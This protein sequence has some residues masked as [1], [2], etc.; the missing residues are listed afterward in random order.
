MRVKKKGKV[1][2][3][4][5]ANKMRLRGFLLK[6]NIAPAATLPTVLPTPIPRLRGLV[7]EMFV[8]A[9]LAWSGRTTYGM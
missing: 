8:P 9:A 4:K 1:L 3:A 5:M 2:A 6:H 7:Y